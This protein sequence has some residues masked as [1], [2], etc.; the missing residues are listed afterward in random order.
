MRSVIGWAVPCCPRSMESEDAEKVIDVACDERTI[1]A[2]FA[3]NK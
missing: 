3:G 1:F 2:R